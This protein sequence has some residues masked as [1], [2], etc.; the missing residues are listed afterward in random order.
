M[1]ARFRGRFDRRDIAN[2]LTGAPHT[3]QFPF[4]PCPLVLS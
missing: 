3:E 1:L 4:S 2:A